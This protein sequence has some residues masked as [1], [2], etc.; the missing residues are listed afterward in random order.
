MALAR[1]VTISQS[2]EQGDGGDRVDDHD[3]GDETLNQEEVS[4][5]T[6][7][8]LPQNVLSSGDGLEGRS[9]YVHRD[10]RVHPLLFTATA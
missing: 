9:S 2:Q 4:T 10:A 7:M 3:Q 8:Q 5:G 1:L 6:G